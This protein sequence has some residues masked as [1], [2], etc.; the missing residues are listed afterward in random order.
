[1]SAQ[2][3]PG[4]AAPLETQSTD[5][6]RNSNLPVNSRRSSEVLPGLDRVSTEDP[7]KCG[8]RPSLTI[9]RIEATQYYLKK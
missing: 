3:A 7:S 1:M 4:I 5:K 9:T 2:L 6:V 8:G